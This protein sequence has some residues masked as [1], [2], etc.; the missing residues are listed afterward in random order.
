MSKTN[1]F[2]DGTFFCGHNNII[3]LGL[4]PDALAVYIVLAIHADNETGEAFPSIAKIAAEAGM[5]KSKN[6]ARAAIMELEQAGAIT[7][8]GRKNMRTGGQT[9]HEYVVVSE[10]TPSID[11]VPT[12][13]QLVEQPLFR[14]LNTPCSDSRTAP[15]QIAEHELDPLNINV[16]NID[17]L[18]ID[19]SDDTWRD[20]NF[21]PLTDSLEGTIAPS[22][23]PSA[24]DVAGPETMAWKFGGETIIRKRGEPW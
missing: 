21:L 6:R 22:L 7:K 23:T 2:V 5:K 17:S 1:R 4:S 3:K 20:H 13:V 15:V 10:V 16:P 11:S 19:P 9:S 18:D 24:G 12:P 8:Q 14:R